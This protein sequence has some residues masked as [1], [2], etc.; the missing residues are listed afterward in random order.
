MLLLSVGGIFHLMEPRAVEWLCVYHPFSF[1]AD[2]TCYCYDS[3]NCLPF[4]LLLC[5]TSKIIGT[6]L[7]LKLWTRQRG[8]VRWKPLL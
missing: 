1:L 5:Y 3:F 7:Q 6:R 8:P 2:A 4:V